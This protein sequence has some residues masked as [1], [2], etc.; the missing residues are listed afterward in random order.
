M[1]I[2]TC[3]CVQ[4]QYT[5]ICLYMVHAHIC[6]QTCTYICTKGM[7]MHAETGVCMCV[8]ECKHACLCVLTCKHTDTAPK[9]RNGRK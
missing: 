6:M 5:G 7:G 1:F 4:A 8:L 9:D 2:D 3:I